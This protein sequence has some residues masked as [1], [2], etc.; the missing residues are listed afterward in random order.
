MKDNGERF[1]LGAVDILRD[2]ER[3]V[4]RYNRFRRLLHKA[5]GQELRGTDR[6][7]GVGRRD[8]AGLQQRPRDGRHDGG[9][10]GRAVARGHGLQRHRLPHLPADGVAPAQERSLPVAGLSPGDLHEAGDRLGGAELD[11]GRDLAALPVGRV[12]DEG[13]GRRQRVQAVEAAG[14]R[15]A[16]IQI[17]AAAA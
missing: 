4:P 17:K 13:T 14:L 15:P 11:E 1:D 6:Q 10:D 12:R 16:A 8:E 3:G 5:A 9:H 7:R 2:R